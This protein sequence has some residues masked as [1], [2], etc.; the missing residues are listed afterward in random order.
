MN[1]NPADKINHT[2]RLEGKIWKVLD[3]ISEIALKFSAFLLLMVILAVWYQVF[4]RIAHISTKGIVEVTGFML[5]W[6]CY[7]GIAYGL[8]TGRHIRVDII[9][10]RMPENIQNLF[11]IIGNL[12]CV[13]FSII[14]T[15]E[16]I[17]LIRMFYEIAQN[18]LTLRIPMFIIYIGMPIGMISFAVEAIREIVLTI[19]GRKVTIP[20]TLGQ[21][22]EQEIE[23][24]EA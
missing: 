16:G 11:L 5:I 15:W 1:T 13:A 8:R 19:K 3:K 12:V 4:A 9:Y 23:G 24:L 14:I 18:S 7:F 10:G 6:V 17:K 2:V 22:V 20:V 21:E